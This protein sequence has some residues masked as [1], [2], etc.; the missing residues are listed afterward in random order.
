MLQRPFL[1][2]VVIA[3]WCVTTGWLTVAKILPAWQPGT[4]PGQQARYA[5]GSRLLPVAWTVTCDDQPLGWAL[6]RLTRTDRSGVI[7]D[8][9]LH[10]ERVPWEELLPGLATLLMRRLTDQRDTRFDARGR[11]AIDEQGTLN[12][13]SSV[14]NLPGADQPVVL[15]GLV[16]EGTVMMH[17]AAGDLRY[18]FKRH[19]PTDMMLGDEFSPHATLPGLAEG[20]RWTV[21]TYNP[22]RAGR[23]PLEILHAEVGPEGFVYWE[24][25]LVPAHVVVYRDDPSTTCE[26]RCR[27]WVDRSG[28]VLRQETKLLGARLAFVRRSDDE[29]ARMAETEDGSA[30]PAATL[31]T[32]ETTTP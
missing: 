4:P 27:L 18:D 15:T 19:L 29:A 11:M 6:T 32:G 8:S 20:R 28:R 2:P 9:H 30:P 1:T 24:D 17:V 16:D 21:P 5:T 22:L 13:F 31:P 7:V 10:L 26:P 25:R 23:A 3:F 12:S 14:V